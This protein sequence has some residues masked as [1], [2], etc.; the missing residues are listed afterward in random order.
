MTLYIL[1]LFHSEITQ[2]Q[3]EN[4]ICFVTNIVLNIKGAELLSCSEK[5]LQDESN[6][7]TARY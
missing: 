4:Y 5:K 7:N 3:F 1:S 2:V 6:G